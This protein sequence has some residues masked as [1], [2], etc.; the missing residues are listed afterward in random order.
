VKAILLII[1]VGILPLSLAQAGCLHRNLL[2]L[3]SPARTHYVPTNSR[4]A[5]LLI[6]EK[7]ISDFGNKSYRDLLRFEQKLSHGYSDQVLLR[8]VGYQE[9]KSDNDILKMFAEFDPYMTSKKV[10]TNTKKL[11]HETFRKSV[12]NVLS[13][14]NKE[15]DSDG[16]T[17]MI[18]IHQGS[19]PNFS[20]SLS[21]TSEY[22]I[23][24]KRA[25]GV[26]KSINSR[27]V[28]GVRKSNKDIDLLKLDEIKPEYKKAFEHE[29]EIFAVGATDPD[30]I[31]FIQKLKMLSFLT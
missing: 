13:H 4:L 1:L 31:V 23:A 16:L 15:V 27:L 8:G 18:K 11:D 20:Y 5:P 22:R 29:K 17:R 24:Q 25:L 14:H 10:I 21:T 26:D 6:D 3:I 28:F 30:A 9:V 12:I 19:A 2:A 7:F